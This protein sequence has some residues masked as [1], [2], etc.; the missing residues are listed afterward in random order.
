[1]PQALEG[2][3]WALLATSRPLHVPAMTPGAPL[4]W[5]SARASP[6]RGT[7]LPV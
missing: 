1:M 2:A 7:S 4:P 5:F 6:Q 3:M